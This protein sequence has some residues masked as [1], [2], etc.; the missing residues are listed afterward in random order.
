[1]TI[2]DVVMF[3]DVA[4]V[5]SYLNS[6]LAMPEIFIGVTVPV[7]YSSHYLALIVFT[8]LVTLGFF[9]SIIIKRFNRR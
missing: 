1:M 2:Y 6:F 9:L 3:K 7:N 4:K 5:M 8:R